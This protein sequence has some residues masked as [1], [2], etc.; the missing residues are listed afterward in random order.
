[1]EEDEEDK[2]QNN[3]AVC[4]H[5]ED[6]RLFLEDGASGAR[7]ASGRGDVALCLDRV[8]SRDGEPGGEPTVGK[9]FVGSPP[10]VAARERVV[11]DCLRYCQGPGGRNVP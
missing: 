1:M 9:V 4:D 6:E 11:V 3:R 8:Q 10:E 2:R 7:P 5:D